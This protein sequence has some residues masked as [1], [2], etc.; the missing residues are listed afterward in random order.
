MRTRIVNF[1]LA[2]TL[3]FAA[4]G[5]SSAAANTLY[6]SPSGNDGTGCTKLAPCRTIGAAVGQAAPGDVVAVASGTYRESVTVAKDI[7]LIGAGATPAVIDASGQT[8]RNS[9]RRDFRSSAPLSHRP[10]Y[11]L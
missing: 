5:A 1:L 9:R 4:L 2:A 11:T 10:R 6:V 8:G 7:K 3:A